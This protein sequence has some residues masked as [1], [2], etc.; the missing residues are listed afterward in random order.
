MVASA[1]QGLALARVSYPSRDSEA[2]LS[3][4]PRGGLGKWESGRGEFLGC[5]VWGVMRSERSSTL[6][7]QGSIRC[8]KQGS[9]RGSGERWGATADRGSRISD[10][11]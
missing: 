3:S 8:V 1:S 9:A 10:R 7:G 6:A 5:E 11:R 2:G 4:Q